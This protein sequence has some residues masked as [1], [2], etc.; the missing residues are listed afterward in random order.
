MRI[1][2]F[3]HKPGLVTR[4]RSI[5]AEQAQFALAP[6]LRVLIEARVSQLNGCVY[7]LHL[8]FREARHR[9]E[10]QHRLDSLTVWHESPHF[11]A[12][13]KAALAW[14][15][16]LTLLPDSRGDDA[17]FAAL[18][19][20]FSDPEIVELSLVISLANFW[21][22]MARGFRRAPEFGAAFRGAGASVNIHCRIA[23]ESDASDIVGLVNRAYRP[24][25]S[26]CGW[27]HEAHLVTGER[28]SLELIRTLFRS[29]SAVLVLCKDRDIVACVHVQGDASAAWIGM[30]ATEPAWQAQGLGKRMLQYAETYA[31]EYLNSEIIQMSV[32]SARPELISFYERR[33]YARTGQMEDYPVAVGIGKPLFDG[34]KVE[35]LT[36][37]TRMPTSQ[38]R[39]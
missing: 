18:K 38:H 11:D 33:G 1:D 36:K 3:S 8:H 26:N 39:A 7:C 28:I 21:N 6:A 23:I 24:D 20:H 4:L 30:L 32:L 14:A 34:L 13:E 19:M 31:V 27:T 17:E 37:Q 2:Y 29:C 9:G 5:T 12:R 10:S 22:H 25:S 35:L 15:E 16:S